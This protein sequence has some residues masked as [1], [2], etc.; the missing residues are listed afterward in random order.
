MDIVPGSSCSLLR[1]RGTLEQTN[2]F[3]D[4]FPGRGFDEAGSW[5]R[6][7]GFTAQRTTYKT[8]WVFGHA[9]RSVCQST[10][11]ATVYNPLGV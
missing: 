1:G 9:E 8:Q 4:S 11:Q 3:S 7:D 10:T 6:P 5:Q 2:R